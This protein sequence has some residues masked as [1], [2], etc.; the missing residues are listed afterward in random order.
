MKNKKLI[1]IFALA[2][3]LLLCLSL[4]PMAAMAAEGEKDTRRIWCFRCRHPCW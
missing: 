1:R 4:L 2:L 3:A